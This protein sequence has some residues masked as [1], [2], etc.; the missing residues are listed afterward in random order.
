MSS[1]LCASTLVQSLMPGWNCVER[2]PVSRGLPNAPETPDAVS[3]KT[4]IAPAETS[5]PTLYI[6]AFI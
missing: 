5:Q 2:L 6:E 3:V 1:A 4:R